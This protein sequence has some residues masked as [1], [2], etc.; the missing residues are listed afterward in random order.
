MNE[1]ILKSLAA[2]ANCSSLLSAELQDVAEMPKDIQDDIAHFS[3]QLASLT[4]T[5]SGREHSSFIPFYFANLISKFDGH[6]F[7]CPL[8]IL[9]SSRKRRRGR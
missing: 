3:K 5:V 9:Q 7:D 8:N 2:W 6:F 4:F 1:Y